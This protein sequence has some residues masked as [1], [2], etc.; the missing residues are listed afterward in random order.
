MKRRAFI[1][2]A[3]LALAACGG[4]NGSAPLSV[5]IPAEQLGKAMFVISVPAQTAQ[6][7]LAPRYISPAAQSLTIGVN[8]AAPSVTANITPGSSGCTTASGG[9][10]TC[11]ISVPAPLGND[12]FAIALYSGTNATGHVLGTGSASASVTQAATPV[13]VTLSGVVTSVTIALA[14]PAPA[15][16]TPVVIPVTVTAKDAS[17]AVIISPGSFSPAITLTDS[18]T[19]GHTALST[20]TLGDPAAVVTLSYD[21]SASLSSATISAALN[22]SI[23]SVTPAVLTPQIATPTPSPTP[24]PTPTPAL[25]A[26][27][28]TLNF[29]LPNTAASIAVSESGYTGTFSQTN[30]CNPGSGTIATLSPASASGPSAAFT[31]TSVNSGLCTVTFTDQNHQSATVTVNVTITQGIIQ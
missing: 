5:S 17:G 12:T 6:A 26:A 14:N 22:G 18:D 3:V 29:T 1:A 20:T 27:P 8:G 23:A 28:A 21:G 4:G 30:T 25:L 11:T 16:G 24:S 15:A 2:L 31:V 13:D 10:T 7:A 19:S 9:A